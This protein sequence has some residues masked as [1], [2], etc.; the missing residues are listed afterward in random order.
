MIVLFSYIYHDT[1]E[2]RL[3][4]KYI[5]LF[6]FVIGFIAATKLMYLPIA[7]IPFLLI[8]GYKNKG[9]YIVLTII[10]FSLLA[11]AI[12]HGWHTFINWHLNNFMHAGQY[13]HGEATIVDV[14]TFKNNLFSIL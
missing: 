5:V 1:S 7:I 12:F 6:S 3:V 13:G 9:L 4:K 11:F 10:A 14:S 2:Q 8:P